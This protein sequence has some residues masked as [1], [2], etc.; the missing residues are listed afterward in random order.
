MVPVVAP[1]GR[2]RF[3]QFVPPW[4]LIIIIVLVRDW[5]VRDVLDVLALLLPALVVF[6]VGP[7]VGVHPAGPRLLR[8]PCGG[9]TRGVA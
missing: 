8:C 1:P 9:P 2:P 4:A 6:A 3:P 5:P 7:A